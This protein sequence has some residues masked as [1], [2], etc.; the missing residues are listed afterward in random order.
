M[1]PVRPDVDEWL[2]RLLKERAFSKL[3]F[4]ELPDGTIR[5]T[6]D[7]ARELSATALLWRTLV[8]PFAEMEAQRVMAVY[9]PGAK[10]ATRLTEENRSASRRLVG[11]IVAKKESEE[12]EPTSDGRRAPGSLS[13]AAALQAKG[14]R[15]R[16]SE[17]LAA[18]LMTARSASQPL[19]CQESPRSQLPGPKV[20]THRKRPKQTRSAV[21]PRRVKST[22]DS[23]GRRRTRA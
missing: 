21:Q 11:K 7:L 14:G 4:G 23:N 1:E 16:R 20:A 13:D 17:K 22:S 9:R 19:K 6:I 15:G 8:G 18:R 5:I 2:L 12:S 3:D 10:V